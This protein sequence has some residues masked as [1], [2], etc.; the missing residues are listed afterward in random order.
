[1]ETQKHIE[2][3]QELFDLMANEH[4]LI[5]L[6]SEMDDIIKAS[7]NVVKK[8]DLSAV[9]INCPDCKSENLLKSGTISWEHYCVNCCTHF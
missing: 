8:Y 5:L 6:Q 2:A 1:M 4:N 7:Q 3:Y 9:V